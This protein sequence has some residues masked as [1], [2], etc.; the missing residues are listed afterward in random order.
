MKNSKISA[1]LYKCLKPTGSKP[2]Q[3]YGLAKVHKEEIPLRPIV[4]IP[5]SS[6]DKIGRWVS[7]WLEKVPESKINTSTE[8]V[9]KDIQNLKL[10]TNDCLVSFDVTQLYTFVPVEE[11]IEMAA[12]KLYQRTDDVP[13]DI[14]TFIKQLL[15]QLNS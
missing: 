8:S 6:Y 13:V 12:V 10:G 15:K 7:K 9:K 11:S 2:A 1:E 14:Q 5:G 3:L 4:S